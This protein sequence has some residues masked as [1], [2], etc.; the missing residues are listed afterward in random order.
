[1]TSKIYK[2]KSVVN[3]K[4]IAVIGLFI[5]IIYKNCAYAIINYDDY[6]FIRS[7]SEMLEDRGFWYTIYYSFFNMDLGNEYRTYGLLRVFTVIWTVLF[8]Y[9]VYAYG[10]LLGATHCCSVVG[11]Y[12]VAKKAFEGG[13]G[14][15]ISMLIAG[16]W[17]FNPFS[18]TQSMHHM[19][20]ILMPVYLFILLLWIDLYCQTGKP[21]L[22][23][24]CMVGI[25]FFGENM[26]ITLY[27]FLIY[28]IVQKARFGGYR[29]YLVNGVI[30]GVL[31]S[32]HYMH[33]KLLR[34]SSEMLERFS[35]SG[36]TNLNPELLV[37]NMISAIIGNVKNVFIVWN[38]FNLGYVREHT[39]VFRIIFYIVLI[40]I[41]YKGVSYRLTPGERV[42]GKKT[43]MAILLCV[44]TYS[45]YLILQ[46]LGNGGFN[47][48]YMMGCV[49]CIFIAI[50][51][52]INYLSRAEKWG[53]N[54]VV[55]LLC[56]LGVSS[57]I[58]YD[59]MLD[60]LDHVNEQ[61]IEAINSGEEANK[62]FVIFANAYPN[63]VFDKEEY[64]RLRQ[65]GVF[66]DSEQFYKM[67]NAST[68]ASPFQMFWSISGWFKAYSDMI[69]I[70][71]YSENEDGTWEL[72][73]EK[74]YSNIDVDKIMSICTE[75][76][77]FYNNNRELQ[78]KV[79]YDMREFVAN[80]P[81]YN[82][83]KILGDNSYLKNTN[84]MDSLDEY[85]ELIYNSNI[86]SVNCGGDTA[87]G[88]LLPDH[89]FGRELAESVRYG[90][91][92]GGLSEYAGSGLKGFD[93]NRNGNFSYMFQLD[94]QQ[95]VVV[96]L[97]FQDIWSN[98]IGDRVF[99]L[100]IVSDEQNITINNID[101]YSIGKN[102]VVRI[103]VP[104]NATDI[105]EISGS[106][107]KGDIPF[108]NVIRILRRDGSAI[109]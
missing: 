65:P 21:I 33:Y 98:E 72:F 100:N 44:S 29:Y 38:K 19:L 83:I 24:L 108:C 99:D 68:V 62:K 63:N 17:L 7:A 79:Y 52:L 25:V 91:V 32:G 31:L 96:C 58:H 26:I 10:F 50:V 23:L 13:L 61:V 90:Y 57:L 86:V 11:V 8:R 35:L 69:P 60:Y 75:D 64:E 28:R 37:D 12:Y 43:F 94:T 66:T 30:V 41:I 4:I 36:L 40:L 9:N 97:E 71:D 87:E 103:L 84:R 59:I 16:I 42:S 51:L 18:V 54:L 67:I 14:E 49:P 92:S 47:S 107:E 105:I 78:L 89:E 53:Q 74:T 55:V 3:I 95:S 1:M 46:I 39:N 27:I 34:Y 22:E 102:G 81:A 20:Y 15:K 76:I 2:E 6:R 70:Y 109:R 101:L 73:G 56:L 80:S 85:Y 5:Y 88:I 77:Y 82:G 106:Q 104:L 45:I 93:T 48:R